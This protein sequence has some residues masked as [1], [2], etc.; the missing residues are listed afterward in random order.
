M[1]SGN[2][3]THE[4]MLDL[5]TMDTGPNAAIV[6]I[7]AVKFDSAAC[8]ISGTFYTNVDLQS[9][10]DA[11]LA[12]SGDTVMWWMEQDDDAR[13]ALRNGTPLGTALRSFSNWCGDVPVW[14]NAATFDND[15]MRNAYEKAGLP[16]PWQYWNDRCYRTMKNLFPAVPKP[17]A[18]KQAHNALADAQWQTLHLFEILRKIRS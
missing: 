4:V 16:C 5:E 14:G 17:P 15:I 18:N 1:L 11:G 13:A 6:S 8:E 7:G 10:L 9:C 12:V 3:M 2:A